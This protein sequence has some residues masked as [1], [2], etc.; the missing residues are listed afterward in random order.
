V[1]S[2]SAFTGE[3]D[4]SPRKQSARPELATAGNDFTL[5]T[6]QAA[7]LSSGGEAPVLNRFGNMRR[8]NLRG[9]GQIGNGT[10]KLQATVVTTRRK[11]EPLDGLFKQGGAGGIYRAMLLDF[12]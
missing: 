1:D 7:L 12:A 5:A 2:P 8:R 9:A 3:R 11:T 10:R 6:A 4:R